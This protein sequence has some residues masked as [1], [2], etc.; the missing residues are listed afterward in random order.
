MGCGIVISPPSHIKLCQRQLA[1]DGMEM[2]YMRPRAIPQLRLE[3][4]HPN[5]TQS[6]CGLLPLP[7][8]RTD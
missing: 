5:F 4:P 6:K 8:H 2:G 7:Q 1:M 3:T